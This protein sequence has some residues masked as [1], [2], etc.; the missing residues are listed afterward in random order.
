MQCPDVPYDQLYTL[1]QDLAAFGVRSLCLSGGE[2]LLHPDLCQI[3]QTAVNLGMVVTVVTNGTLLDLATAQRL[4]TAGLSTLVLSFDSLDDE[5]YRQ[6]RGIPIN[7]ARQAF[8]TLQ[9]YRHGAA[10]IS[11]VVVSIVLTRL[12]VDHLLSH[13]ETLCQW[14]LPE[15]RIMVQAYQPPPHLPAR[16]DPLCFTPSDRT[17]LEK[18]CQAL[19]A[20]Q[21]RGVP[22]GNDATFLARL[23]AFLAERQMPAGY[24]CTIG[25]STLYIKESLDV[26]PCWQLPPVGNLNNIS[27][28]QLWQSPEYVAARARMLNLNCRKCALVCHSPEFLDMLAGLLGYEPLR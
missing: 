5:L 4:H 1:I 10:C 22:I 24:Q 16:D 11:R 7:K 26:H 25:Y 17:R 20:A 3:V 19:V 21:A 9:T 12:I 27:I 23:P 15:D 18:L 6:A 14:L 13:I 2:P 8:Q 28:A